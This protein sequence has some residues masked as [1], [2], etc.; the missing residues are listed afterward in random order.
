[1]DIRS[2]GYV[3]IEST[4]PQKW[5]EFG[6][7]VV[8]LMAAPNMPDDGNVYLK[9]DERPFRFAIVKGEQDR[10]SCAGWEL[11][12]RADFDA[13]KAR[14]EEA[15]VHYENGSAELAETRQVKDIIVLKDPAGNK[16]ELYWGGVL[17][18]AKFVSPQGISGFETGLNGDMGFGHVVLP[19]GNLQDCFEFYTELLGMGVSDYMHFKFSEDPADPGNGL[20]F[21]HC[22]NPRHHSLALYEDGNNPTGCVHMMVETL[23]QDEVGYCLDRV[24][25]ANIPVV[26]TLG[27]HTNDR[28]FSFYMATPGGFALEFGSDGLQLDWTEFTPT[29]TSL[30]SLWGHKFQMPEG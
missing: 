11:R 7:D 5:L 10:L 24:Q 27:R 2:L 1:M 25:A 14:L 8:G 12:D 15:G 30:P 3:V 28:M 29:V 16:L 26:S 17:D 18:F 9:M 22:N 4:D 20:H 13:A 6:T 21:L 23:E 19:C